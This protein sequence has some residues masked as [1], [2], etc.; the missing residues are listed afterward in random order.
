M[1]ILGVDPGIRFAGYAIIKKDARTTQLLDYGC[2][3]LSASKSIPDRI[4]LFHDFFSEKITEYLVDQLALETAFLGENTLNFAKLSYVRGIL[5]L[6]SSKHKL[7]LNEFSPREVKQGITGFG[8]ASKEQVAR[9]VAQ[10]FP[11][12]PT[13]ERNDISDAVA[14]TL[15]ALWQP[16]RALSH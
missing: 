8:G 3:K 15:C 11:S 13:I 4:S 6:L 10:L 2:L 7:T 5:Y 14:I 9:M 1:V 12:L 16:V